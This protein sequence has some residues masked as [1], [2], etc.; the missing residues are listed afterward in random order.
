MQRIAVR[1]SGQ[2]TQGTP[3]QWSIVF[4]AGKQEVHWKTSRSR[5]VR[6]VDVNSLDFDCATP[7]QMLDV[8]APLA[9]EVNADLE[10]FSFST[11]LKQVKSFIEKWGGDFSSLE[12][13]VLEHGLATFACKDTTA[14]QQEAIQALIPP[15]VVWAAITALHRLWPAGLLLAAGIVGLVVWKARDGPSQP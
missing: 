1:A 7:V 8:H 5:Q 12:L 10:P 13:E 11:N 2:A 15:V 14:P 9:G 6:T 3:T 4:D